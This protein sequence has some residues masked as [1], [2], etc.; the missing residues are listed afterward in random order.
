MYEQLLKITCINSLT[1]ITELI[2]LPCVR[3]DEI[4]EVTL[5]PL[6]TLTAPL[7]LALTSELVA[8]VLGPPPVRYSRY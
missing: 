4:L 2:M 1:R 3:Q 7:V 6:A 8:A 5:R